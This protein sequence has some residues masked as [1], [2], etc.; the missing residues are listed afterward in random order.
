MTGIVMPDFK[1][2][3]RALRVDSHTGKGPDWA[4]FMW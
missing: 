4:S 1:A 3:N 2:M